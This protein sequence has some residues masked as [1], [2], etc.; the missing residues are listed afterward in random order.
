MLRPV[1]VS[2]LIAAGCSRTITIDCDCGLCVASRRDRYVWRYYV[3][4]RHSD[5]GYGLFDCV[6]LNH[7]CFVVIVVV[8]LLC[9]CV[10]MR[11]CVCASVWGVDWRD[12]GACSGFSFGL[13]IWRGGE[14][15]RLVTDI[16]AVNYVNIRL[17]LC[18]CCCCCCFCCCSCF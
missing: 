5:D 18:V 10:W 17:C 3:L 1:T 13:I 4:S 11:V 6:G 15:G 14:G 16:V 8:V 9:L 7:S 2:R 12:E